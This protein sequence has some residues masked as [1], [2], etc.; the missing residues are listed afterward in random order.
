MSVCRGIFGWTFGIGTKDNAPTAAE[1]KEAK[2]NRLFNMLQR[3]SRVRIVDCPVFSDYVR[4]STF[5]VNINDRGCDL[6]YDCT[7]NVLTVRLRFEE[8][9]GGDSKIAPF[10]I[11]PVNPDGTI[12]AVG[13]YLTDRELGIVYQIVS[14]ISNDGTTLVVKD[15]TTQ[16]EAV[17][18]VAKALDL[19]MTVE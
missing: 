6:L 12:L 5:K 18:T 4:H 14:G 13:R 3:E 8:V 17:L 11:F 1:R 7:A 2:G 19:A 16:L 10:V 9:R 15:V